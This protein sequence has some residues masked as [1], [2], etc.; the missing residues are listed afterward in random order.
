MNKATENAALL[1][2]NIMLEDDSMSLLVDTDNL[3]LLDKVK[4]LTPESH[5]AYELFAKELHSLADNH[6]SRIKVK[7]FLV[8]T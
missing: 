5:A 2:H 4:A 3:E 6:S 1:Y 8:V 7:V